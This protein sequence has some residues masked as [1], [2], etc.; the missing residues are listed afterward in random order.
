MGKKE[1]RSFPWLSDSTFEECEKALVFSSVDIIIRMK[2]SFLL[3]MRRN[4]P[5][6]GTWGLPGGIIRRG[7]SREEAVH[8][9]VKLETTL[10][11]QK[12]RIIGT[13]DHLWPSRQY[14]STC[15][16]TEVKGRCILPKSTN[17]FSEL[18]FFR[19]IPDGTDRNYRSMLE[20]AGL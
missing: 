2:D 15:Y 4:Q 16:M 10:D 12:I 8:R 18:R 6:S 19:E 9:I 13:Y 17:E 7:E 11:I 20:D 5:G 1:L 3:G 14:V